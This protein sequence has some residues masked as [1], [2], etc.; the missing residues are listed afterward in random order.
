MD[1]PSGVPTWLSNQA[2][3]GTSFNI[4]DLATNGNVIATISS[5][6]KTSVTLSTGS[7]T[8]NRGDIVLFRFVKHITGA[9]FDKSSDQVIYQG[10]TNGARGAGFYKST[11]GGAS[12]TL[13]CTPSASCPFGAGQACYP[14][15]VPGQAGNLFCMGG[16]QAGGPNPNSSLVGLWHTTDGGTSWSEIKTAGKSLE[17]V[18]CIGYGAPMPG[19]DGYP[20]VYFYGWVNQGS[21]Y[22]GGF[23]RIVNADSGSPIFTN[24]TGNSQYPLGSLD[25]PNTCD[26]DGNVAGRAYI[27]F[28][29]SGWQVYQTNWLLRRD[30]DRAVND[31]A[32]MW[33]NQVA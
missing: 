26:G 16:L 32:V 28:Q 21:G 15:A 17:S 20:T 14:R 9:G 24:W 7:G 25:V 33:L 8:V 5:A 29:G 11:N 4:Y 27:G 2:G 13:Q 12:F 1:N 23:W 6:T 3:G 22:V 18:A 31:D 10:I 19:S 30:I